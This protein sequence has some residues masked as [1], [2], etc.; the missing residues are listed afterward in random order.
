MA[1]IDTDLK[2]KARLAEIQ[3]QEKEEAAT[4][5]K[6]KKNSNFVQLYRNA[7]PELRW[8]MNK[9]G[10]AS[11]ILFFILEHMDHRNALVCPNSVLEDRFDISRTTVYRAINLLVENGFIDKMKSGTTNM[12]TVNTQ[13]A[14]SSWANQKQYAKFDGN[15][16]ISK[17]DNKDYEY[18]SQDDRF[19]AL[20]KRENIK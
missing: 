11:S 20:R 2:R 6:E 15:V 12:Y 8:L 1:V 19:K 18:R 17:K 16:L 7:M 14:W 13:V 3:A 4:R 10:T 9:S 5:E